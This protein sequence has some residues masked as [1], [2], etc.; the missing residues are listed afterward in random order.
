MFTRRNRF[1]GGLLGFGAAALSFLAGCSKEDHPPTPKDVSRPQASADGAAKKGE[2]P[3]KY[4]PAQ[5]VAR[6]P[7]D[8]YHLPFKDAVLLDPPDGE[9]RPPDT[10]CAGKNVGKIFDAIAGKDGTGG[11]WDQVVFVDEQGRHLKYRALVTTA[12]GEVEIELYG[13]EAPNHVRSFV[14]LARAGYYD[15]LPIYRSVKGQDE[16]GPFAYVES[17]CP[18]GTGEFGYGSVGYWL[19]PEVSDKLSHEAGTLGALHREERETAA[20]RFYVAAQKMTQFDGAYTIFGKVTRGLDVIRTIN[21]REV[22]EE[23]RLKEPVAI[24][25]VAIQVLTE[26]GALVTSRA[27]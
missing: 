14:A 1:W 4:V 26:G 10:T 19:K 15:G 9:M 13:R 6:P 22:G 18:K 2:T 16:S 27:D 21:A 12:L 5:T 7:Q 23:D 8:K 25:R 17:G 24:R 3:A 11:L 20:C